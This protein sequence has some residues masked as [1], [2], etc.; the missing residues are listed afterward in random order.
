MYG[1]IL[2]E[3]VTFGDVTTLDAKHHELFEES[4]YHKEAHQK[5]EKD[6]P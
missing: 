2:T 1:N 4:K 3:I 5:V 6:M